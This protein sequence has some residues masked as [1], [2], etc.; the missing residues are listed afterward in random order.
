MVNGESGVQ[1]QGWMWMDGWLVCAVQTG[2][3]PTTDRRPTEEEVVDRAPRPQTAPLPTVTVTAAELR[4]SGSSPV[5]SAADV[6][7]ANDFVRPESD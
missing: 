6:H 4:A 1:E 3:R 7:T 5:P 2:Q